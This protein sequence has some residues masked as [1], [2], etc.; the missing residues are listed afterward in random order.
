MMFNPFK[1]RKPRSFYHPLVYSDARKLRLQKLEE[2]AKR[3]LGLLPPAESRAER[4][5]GAFA[6]DRIHTGAGRRHGKCKKRVVLP[7][8]FIWLLL[9][10]L[11]W[12]MFYLWSGEGSFLM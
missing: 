2:K 8:V 11:L 7:N 12:L 10:F 6:Q 9:V 3:D 5:R 4:L 1:V